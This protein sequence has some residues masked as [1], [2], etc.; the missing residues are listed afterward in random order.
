VIQSVNGG[1]Y[2]NVIY[3]TFDKNNNLIDT[4]IEGPIPVC[5]KI[6][7]KIKK[8][9]LV[10]KESGNEGELLNFNF[11]DKIIKPDFEITEIF[12]KWVDVVKPYKEIFA[13]TE[14][15]LV[16]SSD[17]EHI[18]GN[19]VTDGMKEFGNADV[20]ILNEGALRTFWA[21][22]PITYE[23]I[24]NMFPFENKIY[25]IEMTGAEL[26]QTLLVIQSGKKSFY[27]TSGLCQTVALPK[28]LIDVKSYNN[29]IIDDNKTY[30]VAVVDFL[31]NGKGGDD[32]VN[33]LTWYTP[34][35]IKVVGLFRDLMKD[36]LKKIS[37]IKIGDY[38]DKSNPRL[39]LIDVETKFL[40]E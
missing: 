18:L 8:C 2:F 22:G 28:R 40:E 4:K 14:I 1:F 37:T 25:T 39:L 5:E 26:K 23:F 16:G 31:V 29:V 32:F 7:E 12:K 6:F 10:S 21:T 3:F 34:R 11:H 33:V 38:I 15:D 19:L 36:Y 30:V 24:F 13:Y 17:K 27:P 9:N 20:A 35:N